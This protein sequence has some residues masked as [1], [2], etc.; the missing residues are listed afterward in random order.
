MI[1]RISGFL[2]ALLVL[3]WSVPGRCCDVD[4]PP[5]L[6]GISQ[7]AVEFST[8]LPAWSVLKTNFQSSGTTIV[9]DAAGPAD[10]ARFYRARLA[11]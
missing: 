1:K 11:P 5:R 6:F 7:S 8:N 2:V 4:D 9:E 3:G 10:L